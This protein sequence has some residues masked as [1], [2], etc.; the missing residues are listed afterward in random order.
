[1]LNGMLAGSFVPSFKSG[2]R[3]GVLGAR[4]LIRQPHLALVSLKMVGWVGLVSLLTRLLPLPLA[5]QMVQPLRKNG[6]KRQRI[7]APELAATL[8]RLLSAK[9]LFLQP[10]C[11]K[12]AV[13]LQRYLTLAGKKTKVVFGVRD[14]RDGPLSGHAWLEAEGKPL[15]ENS[16]PEYRV[17]Y[18][19]PEET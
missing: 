1:M 7:P 2:S 15:F 13:V 14:K 16:A 5:L 6:R 11:W 17:T 12:R 18:V 4:Q 3:L 9:F 8:D 10:V 19:F